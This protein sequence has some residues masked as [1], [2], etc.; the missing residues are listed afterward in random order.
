MG[1]AVYLEFYKPGGFTEREQRKAERW[2]RSVNRRLSEMSEHIAFSPEGDALKA[3]FKPGPD[4]ASMEMDV[5]RVV[6]K[7]PR[8]EASFE[9]ATLRITDDFDHLLYGSEAAMEEAWAPPAMEGPPSPASE[10]HAVAFEGVYEGTREGPHVARVDTRDG[11]VTVVFAPGG[12]HAHVHGVLLFETAGGKGD[13]VVNCSLPPHEQGT[14]W[15]VRIPAGAVRGELLAEWRASEAPDQLFR[16]PLTSAVPEGPR[17]LADRQK[18]ELGQATAHIDELEVEEERELRIRSRVHVND[19]R[20]DG[21]NHWV[22]L[23]HLAVDAAGHVLTVGE[24]ADWLDPRGRASLRARLYLPDGAPL[25]THRL[26]LAL[27]VPEGEGLDLSLARPTDGT[28]RASTGA[29]E[30]GGF[31]VLAWTVVAGSGGLIVS[32]RLRA[33]EAGVV[34]VHA[35]AADRTRSAWLGSLRAGDERWVTLEPRRARGATVDV[36]VRRYVVAHDGEL[37]VAHR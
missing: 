18:A 8:L 28:V 31:T 11:H 20:T 14:S 3:W 5:D 21:A 33:D 30:G 22:A 23:T 37:Q 15:R 27:H 7:A 36:T 13:A 29:T 9:G 19:A 17:D 10:E 12:E 16:F 4:M 2:A 34:G 26:Q 32:L 35:T 25:A 6:R 24:D 1:Y